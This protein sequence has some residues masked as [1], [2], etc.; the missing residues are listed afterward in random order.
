[1]RLERVSIF[2]VWIEDKDLRLPLFVSGRRSSL[3]DA[4]NHRGRHQTFQH[5]VDP[6][7]AVCFR[8]VRSCQRSKS[9]LRPNMFAQ[10]K[11]RKVVCP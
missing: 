7:I 6:R 3:K 9:L 2:I 4:M 10:L 5:S 11:D 1:M 8:V